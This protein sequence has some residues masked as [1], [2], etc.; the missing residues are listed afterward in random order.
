MTYASPGYATTD[1]E[2]QY[3][4]AISE[5]GEY[6]I[7]DSAGTFAVRRA[8]DGAV[9]L[10]PGQSAATIATRARAIDPAIP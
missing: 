5:R 10:A 6:L 3:E 2:R 8:V 1:L 9:V 7:K 4:Y